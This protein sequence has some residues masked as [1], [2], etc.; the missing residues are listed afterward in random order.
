MAFKPRGDAVKIVSMVLLILS[1]IL[2]SYFLQRMGYEQVYTHLFYIPIIL[3]CMWWQRKG[4]AVAAFL[5][6]LVISLG[7]ALRPEDPQVNNILRASV[8]IVISFMV[9]GLSMAEKKERFEI[10]GEI[11]KTRI[12]TE[13]LAS[14][15]L[16]L[17][18]SHSEISEKNIELE[19][20]NKLAIDREL[21]MIELKKRI[22]ELEK[23]RKQ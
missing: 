13:E 4:I 14:K 22:D 15:N 1:C 16:E 23:V 2:I 3:S 12:K 5:G 7:F 8:F 21:K 18:K 9:S 17:E 19:R 10:A 6:I 11:E 20:I